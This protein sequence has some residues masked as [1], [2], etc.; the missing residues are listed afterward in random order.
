MFGISLLIVKCVNEK[1]HAWRQ[2][3]S[4]I[5]MTTER[6]MDKFVDI[7]ISLLSTEFVREILRPDTY[8]MSY[9]RYAGSN[10]CR[11]SYAVSSIICV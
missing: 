3:Y 2:K 1:M 11:S 8:V 4:L 7:N 10:E 6:F 9:V 5:I